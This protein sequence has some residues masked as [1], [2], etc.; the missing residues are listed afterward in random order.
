MTYAS[1]ARATAEVGLAGGTVTG[2]VYG[3]QCK[4]IEQAKKKVEEDNEE[5]STILNETTKVS[6]AANKYLLDKHPGAINTAGYNNHLKTFNE[7]VLEYL[8]VAEKSNGDS[9]K[10]QRRTLLN[11]LKS[12]QPS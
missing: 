6:Y 12:F 9:C 7:C 11:T 3:S 8:K 2:C 10:D 1:I 5:I 4:S